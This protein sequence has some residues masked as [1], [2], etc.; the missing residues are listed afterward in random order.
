MRTKTKIPADILQAYERHEITLQEVSKLVGKS[1][2]TVYNALKEAGVDT[3]FHRHKNQERNNKIA[4]AYK[5]GKITLAE[6]GKS[7]EGLTKQRIQQII[8]KEKRKRHE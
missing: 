5:T 4:E 8:K 2:S 3:S 7:F 1:V 6:V